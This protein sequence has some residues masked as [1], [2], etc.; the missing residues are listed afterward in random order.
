VKYN[1]IL[2]DKQEQAAA[3]HRHG[4][5][6]YNSFTTMVLKMARFEVGRFTN[7]LLQIAQMP[8]SCSVMPVH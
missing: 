5:F 8:N 4:C 3:T 6:V 7:T 1:L 2:W